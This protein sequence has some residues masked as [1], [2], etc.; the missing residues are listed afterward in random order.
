MTG[1]PSE[2]SFKFAMH[3]LKQLSETEDLAYYMV[4]D[5]PLIDIKGGKQAG[6][7]TVLVE[8]GMYDPS[9]LHDI[10]INHAPYL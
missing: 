7:S 1:K 3:T 9:N 4:G 10:E 5:Y 2:L 6:M 8:S